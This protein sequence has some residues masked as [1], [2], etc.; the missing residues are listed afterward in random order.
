[1]VQTGA[2]AL[3][4]NGKFARLCRSVVRVLVDGG[5]VLGLAQPEGE[6]ERDVSSPPVT[7]IPS[8]TGPLSLGDTPVTRVG[9]GT[10]RLT[11][12]PANQAFLREALGAGVNFIDTAHLYTGGDSE[13]TIGAALAPFPE[14]CL[15]GTKGGY[16]PGEGRPE[17]LSAQIEQSLRSLRVDRIELY[18]LHRVDPETPLE[19]SLAVIREYR[20]QGKIRHVG[21]SA[22]GIDEIERAR[23]VL[24]IAAVQN[25]YNLS[26]RRYDDVV[27][28]CAEEHILFVPYF[29]F[30]GD[31]G[32]A[33]LD[34]AEAHRATPSQ[35]KLA[36]LL[37]RSPM[38]LPIPGTLSAQHLREN[39]A[40]LE[41]ELTEREF[42]ALA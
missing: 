9:L 36:W 23:Q 10:N 35:I 34:I 38:I 32:P 18:Y 15:V 33:L 41:I 6:V 12:T 42:Q 24:P 11:N 40:A 5:F 1:M 3:Q 7:R 22:V 20:D 31:G 28:Y 27:D 37:K 25:H 21:I 19:T 30:R 4:I 14:G 8:M 29:P 13:L 26:E 39:L 16:R 2:G 17:T